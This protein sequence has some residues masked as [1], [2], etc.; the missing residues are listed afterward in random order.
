MMVMLVLTMLTMMMKLS[1]LIKL[2]LLQLPPMILRAPSVSTATRMTLNRWQHVPA[3]SYRHPP[4]QKKKKQESITPFRV[5]MGGLKE[6][7]Q[8]Q[9]E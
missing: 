9:K 1:V 2:L 5:A 8:T 4:P 3:K 7:C 6:N